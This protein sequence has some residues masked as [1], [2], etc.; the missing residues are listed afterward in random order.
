[1]VNFTFTTYQDLT[2]TTYQDI[3]MLSLNFGNNRTLIE[4]TTKLTLG[5]S[6]LRTPTV[7]S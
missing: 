1:M 6:G 5:L 4:E 7:D 2:F 3:R